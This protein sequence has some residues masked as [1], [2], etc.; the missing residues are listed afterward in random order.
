MSKPK[1]MG[2]SKQS[3]SEWYISVKLPISKRSIEEIERTLELL[4]REIEP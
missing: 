4:K 2:W 3:G 1:E